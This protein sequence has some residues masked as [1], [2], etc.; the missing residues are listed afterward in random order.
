LGGKYCDQNKGQENT[1]GLDE[2]FSPKTV[3][4]IVFRIVDKHFDPLELNF[5][6][7]TNSPSPLKLFGKQLTLS[8]LPLIL[9]LFKSTEIPKIMKA[10]QNVRLVAFDLKPIKKGT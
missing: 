4:P 10:Q 1:N 7:Q 8:I 6:F 9:H 2:M 5:I 3:G